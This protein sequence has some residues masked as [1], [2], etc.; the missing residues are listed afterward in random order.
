MCVCVCVCVCVLHTCNV[1]VNVCVVSW[2]EGDMCVAGKCA[3]VCIFMCGMFVCIV[4]WSVCVCVVSWSWAVSV[5]GC[6]CS[7]MACVC[8]GQDVGW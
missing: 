5:P 7:F 3:C 1:Y 4:S 8:W 2:G 6:V